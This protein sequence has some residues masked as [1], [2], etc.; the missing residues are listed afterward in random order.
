MGIV[1]PLVLFCGALLTGWTPAAAIGSAGQVI[2]V[3]VPNGGQAV[4]ARTSDGGAIHLLYNS[5]DIPYYVKS[6]DDGASFSSPIAVVDASS[7]KPGLVFTGMSM[8]VGAR[9]AV[10]VAM[11]TNNWQAKLPDVPEGLVYATLAPDA[12]AF[13]AVRSLNRQPSEGFSLAVDDNGDVAATWLSG[14][15]FANFSRDGGR[16]FTPQCRNQPF[17]SALR[18]LYDECGL[19]CGWKPGSALPR[20]YQQ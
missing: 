3:H 20:A 1:T 13:T 16:T 7:R 15:L 19:C 2:L 11:M 8:D 10:Y 17:L 18:V 14:K 6:S 9:N 5:G 12:K 4:V